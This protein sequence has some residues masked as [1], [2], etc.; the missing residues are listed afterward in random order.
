MKQSA[1]YDIIIIGGGMVGASLACALANTKLRVAMVEEVDFF[2]AN[3]PSFDERTVALAY[4]SKR[5]FETIGV[6]DRIDADAATPI[7]HIHISDRSRFGFARLHAEELGTE[8]LG[9]VVRNRA[10]GAALYQH[11]KRDESIESICPAALTA[12]EFNR[13]HVVVTVNQADQMKTLTAKLVVAADG[14]DSTVRQ[15]AGI[16]MRRS[17]Y[18]QSAVA[19]TVQAEHPQDETAYER[20]TDTGPLALLPMGAG[21]YAV[22][23]TTR[24]GQVENLLAWDNEKFLRELQW[25]FGERLGRFSS[26]SKRQAYPL[27]LTRV[28]E[29]V[30]PRLAL[31]GNA[32]HTV[33]PVAGQGFNLG[34]RDVAA[35]AEVLFEA[36]TEGR[37]LGEINVLQRY[38]VWRRRDN[39]VTAH[40]TDGLTRLFSTQLIPVAWAR[41]AG[42]IVVDLLPPVKRGLMRITS[43]LAGRLPRLARGIPLS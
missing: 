13:E 30:R 32:A 42:L 34:L 20:F 3:Q 26:V 6:W 25:R 5:V 31:I 11:L 17:E 10:L 9:Y 36:K 4:G 27:Y 37:D 28:E 16:R 39:R 2:S 38:A 18:S 24:S 12:I 1:V 35:L 21:R 43:G 19:T 7:K 22:V 33:H 29:H 15:R 14:A 8:A 41:N 40:L 23:W